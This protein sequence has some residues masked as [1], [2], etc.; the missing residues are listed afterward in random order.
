MIWCIHCN[1]SAK[2]PYQDNRLRLYALAEIESDY[3][4]GK[5]PRSFDISLRRRHGKMTGDCHAYKRE[6]YIYL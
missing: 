4:N 2:L 1:V 6:I 3:I 5:L